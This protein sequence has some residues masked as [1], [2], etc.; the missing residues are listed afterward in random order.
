MQQNWRPSFCLSGWFSLAFSLERC[1]GM[2]LV[3]LLS[4]SQSKY[5]LCKLSMKKKSS[6]PGSFVLCCCSS[7][8]HSCSGQRWDGSW[9]WRWPGPADRSPAELGEGPFSSSPPP[10]PSPPP[11]PPPPLFT[12]RLYQPWLGSHPPTQSLMNHLTPRLS[13]HP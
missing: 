11:P 2:W 10:A 8:S 12:T 1:I 5:V 4:Y 7:S 6:E 3:T 9:W 13:L